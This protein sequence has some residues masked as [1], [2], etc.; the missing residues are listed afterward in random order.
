MGTKVKLIATIGIIAVAGLGA[1]YMMTKDKD[2]GSVAIATPDQKAPIATQP[3]E[4][5]PAP[6]TAKNAYAQRVAEG[7][8]MVVLFDS[9]PFDDTG[10]EGASDPLGILK[11]GEAY[12]IRFDPATQ[13]W[14]TSGLEEAATEK[15]GERRMKTHTG[16]GSDPYMARLS[17]WGINFGVN[18]NG[19]VTTGAD[20]IGH[21][22]SAE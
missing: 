22:K 14:T 16:A 5:A 19:E 12:D 17:M 8:K 11:C 10:W 7:E 13:K 2:T 21:L 6:R 9:C 3:V 20:I 15:F 18:E 4:V 1:A